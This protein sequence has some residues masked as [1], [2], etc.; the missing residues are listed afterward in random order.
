MKDIS[1]NTNEYNAQ[2]EDNSKDFK[3]QENDGIANIHAG[4]KLEDN[5]ALEK[6]NSKDK[7][8]EFNENLADNLPLADA[9]EAGGN[10]PTEEESKLQ[11]DNT[12]KDRENIGTSKDNSSYKQE[13]SESVGAETSKD[14]ITYKEYIKQ[15]KP[16]SVPNISDMPP[17]EKSEKRADK[18]VKVFLTV[19]GSLLLILII[20]LAV[21]IFLKSDTKAK[22]SIFPINE[23]ENFIENHTSSASE[24]N[25]ETLL[26]PDSK[27]LEITDIPNTSQNLSAEQIYKKNA[28]SVVGVVI[29]D[30]S[31]DV[32]SDPKGE[33]S[34]IV[35]T[36]DGYV[37]TNSHVIGDSKKYRIKIITNDSSEYSGSVVG[38]DTRTD[39]A[40]VKVNTDNLTP[41]EFGNSDQLSVGSWVLAIGNPGGIDFANSLTRG[42][43]SA[44][45]RSVSNGGNIKYIQTD[46]AINP[47]NSGGALLNMYGQ[48]VGINTSKIVATGYEGMGF[49]I[50]INTAKTIINDI[51]SQGYVS[52]RVRL[53]MTGKVISSYQAETYSVP[54]GIVIADISEDSYLDDAGVETGDIITKID[55]VSTTSF[56]ILFT[57]LSKHK[58]GDIVTLTI[59]RPQSDKSKATTFEAKVKLLE[60]KGETQ[61]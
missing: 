46:A 54:R 59:Y 24:D 36:A 7:S 49:S 33:G 34:G 45:N 51:I 53:G 15:S 48:V 47:G 27:G 3:S 42:I 40:V 60:D 26:N 58:P 1:P 21:N 35:L 31:A 2:N 57:E 56:D 41:A 14:S 25:N 38:Y 18:D 39:L 52:G 11:I 23:F 30:P 12:V 55:S 29:Y 10:E 44:L 20:A 37:V 17:F 50:P 9:N 28:G 6:P 22:G 8:D 4:E 5:K 16:N 13:N 61:N 19:V 43:V 32:T